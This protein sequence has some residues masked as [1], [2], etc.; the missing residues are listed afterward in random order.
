MTDDEARLRQIAREAAHEAVRETLTILGI[1][2]A[3]PVEFQRK[4]AWLDTAQATTSTIGRQAI[5]STIGVIVIGVLTMIW[6][7]VGGG[8]K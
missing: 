6:L 5:T 3:K 7:K 8:L 4:M 1:D 2:P